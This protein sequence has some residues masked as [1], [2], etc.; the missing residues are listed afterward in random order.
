MD[1]RLISFLFLAVAF[2][3]LEAFFPRRIKTFPR[4]RKRWPTHLLMISLGN[5]LGIVLLPWGIVEW[6]EI[7]FERQWGLCGALSLPSNGWTIALTLLILDFAIYWQHRL[8]HASP[9]LWRLHQVHHSDR[10]LD[11]SSALRFHPLEIYLSLWIKLAV[12]T[13]G[14]F[15]PQGVFLFEVVLNG[16]ALFNHSNF[17][18]PLWADRFLRI[19]VVTPDFHRLHHSRRKEESHAHFGFNLP[20]WDYLLG[21]SIRR[22]FTYQ[23]EMV[24]GLEGLENDNLKHLLERPF[25]TRN[26][27]NKHTG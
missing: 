10:Y 13:L 24:L 6:S 27:L 17:H 22:P 5:F 7:V 18:L 26:T 19:F 2:S 20:W 12:I 21:T 8:F 16:C 15:P 14:G 23:C 25:L 4:R 9:L 11:T 3:I 1:Q